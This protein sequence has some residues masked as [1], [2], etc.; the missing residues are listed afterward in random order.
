MEI[1]LSQPLIS[2]LNIRRFFNLILLSFSLFIT[3]CNNL[4]ADLQS[5]KDE[6]NAKYKELAD[7]EKSANSS[8]DYKQLITDYTSFKNEIISYTA[9]CNRRGISKENEKL[10]SEI[11]DKLSKFES[12]SKS[13]N[14]YSSGNT[15]SS[16]ST[17]YDK[18]TVYNQGMEDYT[19][20]LRGGVTMS[21]SEE[22]MVFDVKFPNGTDEDFQNYKNGCQRAFWNWKSN[23][24]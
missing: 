11:N 18:N 15:S 13:D 9:E 12:L 10:V 22:R 5:R 8:S 2:N 17:S 23:G 21:I 6:C 19:N 16:S 20:T 1:R 3:S 4:P 7:Q 24:N 14:S